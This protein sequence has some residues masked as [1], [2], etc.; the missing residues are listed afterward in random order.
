MIIFCDVLMLA[1]QLLEK[2]EKDVICLAEYYEPTSTGRDIKEYTESFEGA[3][4]MIYR[5]G[6]AVGPVN[7]S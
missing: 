3:V 6:R 4:Y 7:D 2:T 1:S 5:F